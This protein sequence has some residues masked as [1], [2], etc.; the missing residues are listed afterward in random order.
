MMTALNE[1]KPDARLPSR[2]C[3]ESVYT[4][5]DVQAIVDASIQIRNRIASIPIR[6]DR[7]NIQYHLEDLQVF[8]NIVVSVLDSID[9]T[10]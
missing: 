10:S 9:Q 5:G 6:A 4:A 8:L 1:Y 3:S 2:L 7:S